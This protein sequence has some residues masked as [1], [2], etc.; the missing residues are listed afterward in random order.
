[1]KYL[2]LILTG[3]LFQSCSQK[4]TQ[5]STS[6][7]W[8]EL[9]NGKNLDGWN[10]KIRG[11]ELNDNYKN[12]F[13]VEDGYLTVSYDG[14]DDFAR[15]YGHIFYEKPYSYY[16][17]KTTHRFIGDQA[18]KGEGWALRNSGVMIHGQT[19]ESMGLNQDFPISIEVQLLGGNSDGKERSTC[20]LCT[21]GTNVWYNGKLDTR[22]CI[23]S[24]SK[25]YNGDQWVTAEIE[26]YGDS[27]IRHFVNGEK[28]LEYTKPSVGSGN[29]SGHDP[30]FKI[31]GSLLGGGTISLQSESHP[32]QFKNVSIL[33]LV[34]CMDP[35]AT[36]YKEYYVKDGG[37]CTYK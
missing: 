32:V 16:K 14:Y 5:N 7:E 34:G 25:T 27:L 1:M 26:V 37:N 24:T 4:V 2:L 35:K 3:F 17:L 22:H 21:P 20:N 29:V 12:T 9:F 18:P 13:R 19:A 31:D 30:K 15:K 6:E 36:N 23:S 8:Q 10:V 11:N 33:N 28:V